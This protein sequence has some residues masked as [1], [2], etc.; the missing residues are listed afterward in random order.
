MTIKPNEKQT[1]VKK[2]FSKFIAIRNK[3]ITIIDLIMVL[4]FIAN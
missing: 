2:L 3:T 4:V 1:Q